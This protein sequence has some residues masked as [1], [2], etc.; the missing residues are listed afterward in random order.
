VRGR[1]EEI[2]GRRMAGKRDRFIL[3]TKCFVPTGPAPMYGGNSRK[4]IMS[5]V[6]GS[7]R[8]LQTDYIDLYQLHGYDQNT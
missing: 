5:A 3:A 2:I 8:R 7:L 4:H 1:T 6:E